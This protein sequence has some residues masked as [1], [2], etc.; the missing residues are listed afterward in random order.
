AGDVPGQEQTLRRLAALPAMGSA[1]QRRDAAPPPDVTHDKGD[2]LRAGLPMPPAPPAPPPLRRWGAAP[3]AA[4]PP[5]GGRPTRGPRR[6]ARSG[7]ASLL[8]E[9]LR[10]EWPKQ[11][12]GW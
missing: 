12:N 11:R 9:A 8:G 7:Q 1:T 10:K 6:G 4:P 5:A 2:K 3:R